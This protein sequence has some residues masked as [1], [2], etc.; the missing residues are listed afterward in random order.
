VEYASQYSSKARPGIHCVCF[1]PDG[2]YLVVG[3][4]AGRV[5]VRFD[6]L[7]PLLPYLIFLSFQVWDIP[8]KRIRNVFRGH[9]SSVESVDFSPNGRLVV[10][11]S[12]DGTVRIWN[13]RDGSAKVFTDNADIFWSV[14][15]SPN[16]QYV[17]AGNTDGFLRIWDVRTGRLVKRWTGHKDG[18]WSVAFTPDGKGLVSGSGDGVVKCWDVSSLGVVQSSGEPVATEIMEYKGHTVRLILSLILVS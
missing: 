16:G 4:T 17:A 7:H 14:R 1:S 13:V 12:W 9:K 15:F 3:D 6:L 8:N 11:A 18:V 10:S 2:R 5:T